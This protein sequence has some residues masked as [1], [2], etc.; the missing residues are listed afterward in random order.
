MAPSKPPIRVLVVTASPDDGPSFFRSVGPLLAFPERYETRLLRRD[1]G[2][3]SMSWIDLMNVD[4][5][6]FARPAAND[7]LEILKYVQ[8]AGLPVNVDYDDDLPNIAPD[9]PAFMVYRSPDTIRIVETFC[10]E[11]DLLT[12]ST[13]SI[14]ETLGGEVVSNALM[15]RVHL[16]IAL[17]HNMN[18][19]WYWRGSSTHAADVSKYATTLAALK[20]P[21]HTFGF[22]PWPLIQAGVECRHASE[23]PMLQYLAELR[24]AKPSVCVV[25]LINNKFNRGKSNIAWLEATMAGAV[26]VVSG[27][28]PEF[29]QPGTYT[30]ADIPLLEMATSEELQ[31]SWAASRDTAIKQSVKAHDR[32]YELLQELVK[33]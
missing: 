18:G 20:R 9:N 2:S 8:A 33:R 27:D 30:F 13:P 5:V 21:L 16:P 4:V 28:L 32:R 29:R 22:L 17:A 12:V 23:M 7:A 15:P 6:H 31:T 10:K 11:A 14:K 24:A 3:F 1:A 19:P 25:P 26:T